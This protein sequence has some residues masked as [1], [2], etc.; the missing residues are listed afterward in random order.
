[1][2]TYIHFY[3]SPLGKLAMRSDGSALIGL[4]LASQQAAGVAIASSRPQEKSLPI[5]QET[6]RWLDTYFRGC[7]PSFT[8]KL[9][10]TGSDFQKRVCEIMLTIPYGKTVTY[11]EIAAQIARERGIP[12][13]SAQ[14]VGG[15]VGANPILL[16][17]PCH[18]VIG[19]G[20]NLTGYGAGM[21]RKIQLLTLEK[22]DMTNLFVPKGKS[23]PKKQ[24][25]SKSLCPRLKVK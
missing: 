8:P 17:V 25:L 24:P 7:A 18:R 23:L 14:A 2:G 1:M 9:K 16:I 11:G 6:G 15:A 5:F 10:L 4:G 12:R 19:A 22:V 21:E 13:M 3:D 20:G